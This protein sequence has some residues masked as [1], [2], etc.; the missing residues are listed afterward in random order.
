MRIGNLVDQL[1]SIETQNESI[2]LLVDIVV[3]TNNELIDAIKNIIYKPDNIKNTNRFA[4]LLVEIPSDDYIKPLIDM[5]KKAELN[6]SGWLADYMYALGCLLEERD[7]SWD[8]DDEIVQKLGNWM[9]HTNG[10]EISWK[11]SE[12]L[13]QMN[14]PITKEI[15]INGANNSEL[16]I[17]TRHACIRGL[18]NRHRSEAVNILEGMA[19]DPIEEIQIHAKQ[20]I[21]FINNQTDAG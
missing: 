20:A 12:I 18:V 7:D 3:D 1:N 17:L 2:E 9:L 13:E 14:N 4:S 10:G 15:Y 21:D 11:A 8:A 19:N 16:F 6:V 5:I